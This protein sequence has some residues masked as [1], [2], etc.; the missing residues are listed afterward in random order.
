MKLEDEMVKEC[1]DVNI[2]LTAS[3]EEQKI[4]LNR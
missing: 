4:T 1:L 3:Q 2:P